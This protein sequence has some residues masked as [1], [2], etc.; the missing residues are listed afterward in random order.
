MTSHASCIA[1]CIATLSGCSCL[2]ERCTLQ[3]LSY[4]KPVFPMKDPTWVMWRIWQ[5]HKRMWVTDLQV[6]RTALQSRPSSLL[7]TEPRTSDG[8]VAQSSKITVVILRT[9]R[10]SAHPLGQS[11]RP[12]L[13]PLLFAITNNWLTNL[14][15]QSF[16]MSGSVSTAF[17]AF[18]L[19]RK[20][21]NY[22]RTRYLTSLGASWK[23]QYLFACCLQTGPMKVRFCNKLR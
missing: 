3:V 6:R 19:G 13:T 22:E 20:D 7:K 4:R 9:R 2:A 1:R 18:E 17:R 15:Y 21:K 23:I 14:P 5:T 12:D 10:Y 16:Q 11:F 8:T